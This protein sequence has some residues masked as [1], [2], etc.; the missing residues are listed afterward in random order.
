MTQ[1]KIKKV[2]KRNDLGDFQI[3]TTMPQTIVENAPIKAS[4]GLI[5][6][7]KPPLS[8]PKPRSKPNRRA[9]RYSPKKW[10]EYFDKM[11]FAPDVI[12][13]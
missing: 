7:S 12:I 10:D 6:F 9:D 2:I 11:N 4:H 13:F 1:C 8:M 3:H 5:G